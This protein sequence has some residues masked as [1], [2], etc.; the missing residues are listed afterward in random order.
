MQDYKIPKHSFQASADVAEMLSSCSSPAA[1][2]NIE[3]SLENRV[4]KI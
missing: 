1:K 2:Q 3:S 4:Q